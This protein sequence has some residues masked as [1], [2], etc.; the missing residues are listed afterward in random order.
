MLALV[1][2]EPIVH[3]LAAPSLIVTI[4]SAVAT[5]HAGRAITLDRAGILVAPKGAVLTFESP[6]P[7]SRVA[8]AGMVPRVLA[9]AER[10]Y[11]KLGFDRKALARW[12]RTLAE[13]PRT[14]WVHELVHR[15]VFERHALGE[16]DNLA[17]RFLEI[18]LAKEVYFLFR[19][20]E[21]GA[22]RATMVRAYSSPI[23]RAL[24]HVE[25]NLWSVVNV[26]QLARASGASPSSLA[27]A[28][29]AE[30]GCSPGA[31]WRNRKLDEALLALRAGRSVADVATR[32][33]Y[34]NPTAFGFAF[35]RRFGRPPSAFRPSGRARCAP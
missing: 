23:E 22:E 21:Q 12:T 17:T 1:A 5:V 29:H 18:E 35:R 31:Y 16:S 15:Y 2:D 9:L 4:E 24:A 26:S 32:V 30:V 8:I 13:L 7:S 19:D 20:R 11:A 10:D 34:E 27:R 14:V 28:F 33:G 25:A 6:G 3:T